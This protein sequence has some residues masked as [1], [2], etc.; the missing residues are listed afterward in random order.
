MKGVLLATALFLVALTTQ[1]Q[2]GKEITGVWWNAE[3]KAKIEVYQQ[4]ST[5]SGKIIW[6][7]VTTN[8]DGSTP[9]VDE[10]NPDAKEAKKPLMGKVVLKNLTWEGGNEYEGGSIYDPKTGK[11]YSCEAKLEGKTLYLRGYIGVSLIGKT[12]EWTRAE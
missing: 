2:N 7:K 3:K 6:L 8:A 12:S 9:R 5:F 10:N 11:T 4:G 1:A